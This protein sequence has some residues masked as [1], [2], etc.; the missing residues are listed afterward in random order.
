MVRLACVAEDLGD[1]HAQVQQAEG[2]RD[3]VARSCIEH[4][5]LESA[6]VGQVGEKGTC[7]HSW[8]AEW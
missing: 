5:A 2:V 3:E 4:L 6:I 1:D 8:L 7:A